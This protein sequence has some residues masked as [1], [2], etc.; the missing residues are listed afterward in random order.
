M[1]KKIFYSG[2]LLFLIASSG[3][4]AQTLVSRMGPV[5]F[6]NSLDSA[7][8]ATLTKIAGRCYCLVAAPGFHAF[9]TTQIRS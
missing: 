5:Q 2:F 8:S 9:Q 3:T 1:Q 7:K 4:H 6:F